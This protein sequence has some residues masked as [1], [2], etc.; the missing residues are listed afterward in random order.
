MIFT[1]LKHDDMGVYKSDNYRLVETLN[2]AIVFSYT[3]QGRAMVAHLSFSKKGIRKLKEAI[4]SFCDLMF[5]NYD[6]DMVIGNVKKGGS[7]S[8]VL[9][10][11]GCLHIADADNDK[12]IYMK[13]RNNLMGQV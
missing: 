10:H 11:C 3:M 13:M 9:K 8:R 7:V 12:N 1:P 4:N 6:I 2:G 5:N